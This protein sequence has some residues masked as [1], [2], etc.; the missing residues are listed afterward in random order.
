MPGRASPRSRRPEVEDLGTRVE[1]CPDLSSPAG[2]ATGSECT[3]VPIACADGTSGSRS[4]HHALCFYGR[5]ESGCS[6]SSRRERRSTASRGGR[7]RGPE[8]PLPSPVGP[9]PRRTH[10]VDRP[11]PGVPHRHL[12]QDGAPRARPRTARTLAQWQLRRRARPGVAVTTPH[13]PADH[14]VAWGL[15]WPCH[16]IAVPRSH[17]A[18]SERYSGSGDKANHFFHTDEVDPSACGSTDRLPVHVG[19]IEVPKV[20]S[21]PGTLTSCSVGSGAAPGRSECPGPLLVGRVG[22]TAEDAVEP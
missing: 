19:V 16:R 3:G 8:D 11:R 21:G 18:W 14:E 7:S 4:N 20:G 2:T 12:D 5:L 6:L 17:L 9:G 1:R 10:R 22:A 15:K 13:L